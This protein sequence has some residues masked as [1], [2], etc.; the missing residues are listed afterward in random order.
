M[1]LKDY[2]KQY[3]KEQ[4]IWFRIYWFFKANYLCYKYR[5]QDLIRK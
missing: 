4:G 2:I 3:R 1:E 5:I